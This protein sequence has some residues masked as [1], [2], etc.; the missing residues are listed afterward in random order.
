MS[1]STLLVAGLGGGELVLIAVLL[2][3]TAF[4]IWMLVDCATNET[5]TGSKVAWILIILFASCL[6]A[7]V[8]FLARKLPRD[9]EAKKAGRSNAPTV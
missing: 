1:T 5:S 3:T 2:A 4:W 6:G 9:S 8:Y 7:P